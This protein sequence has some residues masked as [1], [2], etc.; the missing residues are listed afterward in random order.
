MTTL[1]TQ[2]PIGLTVLLYHIVLS[3]AG[4]EGQL[5][6]D[7]QAAPLRCTYFQKE[8]VF[9]K[10]SLKCISVSNYKLLHQLLF[11]QLFMQEV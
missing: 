10:V 9:L 5:I 3:F 4:Q 7:L 1:V 8:L 6:S 2:P 11:L